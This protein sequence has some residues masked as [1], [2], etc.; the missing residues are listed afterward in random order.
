[1]ANAGDTKH[2]TVPLHMKLPLELGKSDTKYMVIRMT[3]VTK[4]DMQDAMEVNS[5]L[6]YL[7]F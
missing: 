4:V 3:S 6:P 2:I 1:M 5:S 7:K